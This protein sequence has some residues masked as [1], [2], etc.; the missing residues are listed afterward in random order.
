M[1]NDRKVREA[2]ADHARKCVAHCRVRSA[3]AMNGL[4]AMGHANGT[5]RLVPMAPM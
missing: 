3:F 4:D 2:A 5:D 1:A